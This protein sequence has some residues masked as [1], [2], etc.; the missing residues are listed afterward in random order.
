[1]LALCLQKLRYVYIH[2]PTHML[3]VSRHCKLTAPTL[4]YCDHV[5]IILNRVA[6]SPS[7]SELPLPS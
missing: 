3:Y 5:M 4:C 6:D 7:F 1:M 2:V